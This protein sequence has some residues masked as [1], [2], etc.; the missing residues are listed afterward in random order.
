MNIKR[1]SAGRRT[2]MTLALAA[3]LA[4]FAIPI[5]TVDGQRAASAPSASSSLGR[6]RMRQLLH[7]PQ[8]TAAPK[9]E[10]LQKSEDQKIALE[11]I[12]FQADRDNW[13]P[14]IVAKPRAAAQPLPAIICLPGTN[15]TRQH[16]V[17]PTLQL[18][19]FPRTG[20][21]RALAGQGFVT[22]SLDYRG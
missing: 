19:K 14:A 7:L 10:V 17:D 6:S 20:W 2:C 1:G 5:A 9:V 4:L 11:D 21:A 8:E 22:L 3:L 18:T 13:V 12:K 15:G 16:L